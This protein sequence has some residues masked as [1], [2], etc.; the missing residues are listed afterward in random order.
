[1]YSDKQTNVDVDTIVYFV[2]QSRQMLDGGTISLSRYVNHPMH[3]LFYWYTLNVEPM[4][5]MSIS[6]TTQPKSNLFLLF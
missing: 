5:T 2:I 6:I 4:H 1:M 3:K